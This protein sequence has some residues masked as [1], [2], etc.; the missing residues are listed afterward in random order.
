MPRCQILRRAAQLIGDRSSLRSLLNVSMSDLHG[1]LAGRA[2]PPTQV[3]LQAVDIIEAHSSDGGRTT[4][5]RPL[6][7]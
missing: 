3:F 6:P 2:N 4:F 5:R 1:W 7:E